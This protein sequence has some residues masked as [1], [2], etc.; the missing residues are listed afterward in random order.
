MLT[1]LF[2]IPIYLSTA[3]LGVIARAEGWPLLKPLALTLPVVLIA[4][5][6]SKPLVRR[7]VNK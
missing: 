7:L 2:V 4:V 5:Y 6:L 1:S 3:L